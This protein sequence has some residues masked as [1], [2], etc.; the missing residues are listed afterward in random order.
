MRHLSR[1]WRL[2]AG[3]LPLAGCGAGYPWGE[4]G[5]DAIHRVVEKRLT[6]E[7]SDATGRERWET[8]GGQ[9]YQSD[10]DVRLS[11]E[12]ADARRK[13]LEEARRLVEGGPLA[14]PR[15][16]AFA[17]EF[18]DTLQAARAAMRAESGE[19]VIARSRF[20]PQLAY[21]IANDSTSAD[22]TGTTHS[23]DHFFRLSQTLV[24]FGRENAA[25]VAV[26]K[27][28]RAALFAYED[29]VRAT[30]SNVRTKFFTILLRH[31][32]I[33]QRRKLLDEFQA[34]YEKMRRL[35]AGRRVLEVDVLTAR[36]NMLN[37]EARI[38]S[39]E[40]EMLRQKIDLLHLV[41]LP[42]EM[43]DVELQGEPEE[44]TLDLE[45]S[46]AIGLRRSTRIASVRADAAEQRRV[47][48]DVAWRRGPGLFAR[49]GATSET[50]A[51]GLQLQNTEGV[52]ALSAF[53]EQ[54]LQETVGGFD[55]GEGLFDTLDAGWSAEVRLEVPLFD[56][57]KRRGEFAR[58]RAK[59][60]QS[61]HTLR[62]AVDSVEAD[63]RKDYQTLLERRKELDI[64]KET[65]TI[66][67]ERLR[68]QERLKELGKITDNELETFRNRFF[69][70]Q[71][72]FFG[73]QISLMEAQEQLRQAMRFFEPL[74][75][76]DA[77]ESTGPPR[78]GS[79][80]EP[81]GPSPGKE[82]GTGEPSE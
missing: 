77:A 33:D 76:D 63:I 81:T 31:Q 45:R 52:F 30:L 68:V 28:E 32:Q 23:L 25:D 40:K 34:R 73:R 79:V 58:E 24:E 4:T 54:H 47:A 43:T 35:E 56:G 80:D 82:A 10:E 74:R 3:V 46:I 8:I 53:G 20:L 44:F 17:L 19:A 61:L 48:R 51:A 67:K 22:G 55:T 66:S 60:V 39:L 15:C 49:A 38:N 75:P 36:L 6:E 7:L 12:R 69:A 50:G 41:G 62:D 72:V 26:R 78:P 2:I 37:E 42:V 65:V 5:P 18:N 13:R 27:S 16:L 71:D 64:L 21:S 57:F 14:L 70:D 9:D 59:L 29:A 11:R 1:R